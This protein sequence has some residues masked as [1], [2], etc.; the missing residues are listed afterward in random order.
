MGYRNTALGQPGQT[1]GVG[2]GPWPLDVLSSSSLDAFSRC[3]ITLLHPSGLLKVGSGQPAE[4]GRR[5]KHSRQKAWRPGNV[6]S[7]LASIPCRRGDVSAG[8]LWGG[9][10][11]SMA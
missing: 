10:R 6:C 3:S 7:G 11:G 2:E 1:W 4:G 9:A 8:A 5:E